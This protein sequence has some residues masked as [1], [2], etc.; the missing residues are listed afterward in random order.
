[1]SV[2]LAAVEPQ[3]WETRERA[4][5]DANRCRN[6]ECRALPP[7]HLVDCELA[8]MPDPDAERCE[9]TYPKGSLGCRLTHGGAA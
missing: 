3:D 8:P 2:P 9:C 7:N 6:P 1:M 4:R 5:L